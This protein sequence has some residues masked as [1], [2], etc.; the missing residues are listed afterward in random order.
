MAEL[1]RKSKEEL[2]RTG[3]PEGREIYCRSS[4]ARDAAALWIHPG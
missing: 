1:L 3:I 2:L 4:G